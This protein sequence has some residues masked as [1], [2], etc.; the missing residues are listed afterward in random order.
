MFKYYWIAVGAISLVCGVQARA[1]VPDAVRH[2]LACVESVTSGAVPVQ[3]D[4]RGGSC[5]G[6]GVYVTNNYAIQRGG[7]SPTIGNSC[8][9][10]LDGGGYILSSTVRAGEAHDEFAACINQPIEYNKKRNVPDNEQIPKLMTHMMSC[11][12]N[13]GLTADIFVDRL[14]LSGDIIEYS[15]KQGTAIVREDLSST[16]ILYRTVVKRD[17]MMRVGVSSDSGA[18]DPIAL[19]EADQQ[20]L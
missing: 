2:H 1:A 16:L 19:K 11:A 7:T 6:D 4:N 9:L 5:G 10:E 18:C 3:V 8:V 17:G 20:I 13:E 14:G 15:R 12:I